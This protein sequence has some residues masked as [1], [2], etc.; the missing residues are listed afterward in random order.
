[1]F[2]IDNDREK[3]LIAYLYEECSLCSITLDF[4]GEINIINGILSSLYILDIIEEPIIIKN[5]YGVI[6]LKESIEKYTFKI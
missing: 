3:I 1:M 2:N 4:E 6:D 5:Y